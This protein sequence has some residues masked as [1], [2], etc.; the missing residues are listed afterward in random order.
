MIEELPR[1]GWT[2]AVFLADLRR[3]LLEREFLDRLAKGKSGADRDA[4][5]NDW[6]SRRAA[7]T[8]VQVYFQTS[9]AGG[10]DVLKEAEKAALGYYQKKY[11]NI[12]GLTAKAENYGCH[13][14]VD[15]LKGGKV[16]KSFG[17][18]GGEI[19]EI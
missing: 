18:G 9:A 12:R 6:L 19:Y 10:G 17:Y 4:A 1:Y 14:Q 15:I 3:N 7:V 13:I 5:V 11:G 8:R 16:L 2:K